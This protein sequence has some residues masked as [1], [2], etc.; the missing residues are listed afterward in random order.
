LNETLDEVNVPDHHSIQREVAP[1]YWE[2]AKPERDSSIWHR[3]R[4]ERHCRTTLGHCFHPEGF[5]DWFC[6]ECGAETDGMPPQRCCYCREDPDGGG[7][8]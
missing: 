4:Q 8:A 5:S 3:W 1:G 6:C 7:D 2:V